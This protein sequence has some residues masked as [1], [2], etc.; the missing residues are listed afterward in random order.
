MRT[1]IGRS[2]G[3]NQ[4]GGEF[5]ETCHLPRR[6][7]RSHL[8]VSFV[9]ELSH[10]F[11]GSVLDLFLHHV[12]SRVGIALA[13]LKLATRQHPADTVVGVIG[14]RRGHEISYYQWSFMPYC[15]ILP[16]VSLK[17]NV[18]LYS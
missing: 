4:S 15:L 16:L 9:C 18:V 8:L 2:A 10:C 11:A 5:A 12:F 1:T 3:S 6:Y 7:F 17:A 14:C 13:E